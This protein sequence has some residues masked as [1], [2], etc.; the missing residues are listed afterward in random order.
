MIKCVRRKQVLP[1]TLYTGKWITNFQYKSTLMVE[2]WFDF[3]FNYNEPIPWVVFVIP[4]KTSPNDDL[5]IYSNT[6]TSSKFC[7]PRLRAWWYIATPRKRW[8]LKKIRSPTFWVA[9]LNPT[10]S[11]KRN[12][13]LIT[14]ILKYVSC[15]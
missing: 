5:V 10:L 7:L 3:P 13:V 1:I 15:V 14:M 9:A 12:S 4:A 2:F 11:V 8:S 6:S